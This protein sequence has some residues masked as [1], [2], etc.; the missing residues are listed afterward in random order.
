M[1]CGHIRDIDKIT[2]FY[3][4]LL[5]HNKEASS[6]VEYVSNYSQSLKYFAVIQP[7]RNV[8][9]RAKTAL[10]SEP[11]KTTHIHNLDIY[12]PKVNAPK[13]FAQN[14]LDINSKC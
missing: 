9:D 5:G 6:N 14:A 12:F 8:T 4:T 2:T 1:L 13:I 3:C 10:I 11:H 7:Q